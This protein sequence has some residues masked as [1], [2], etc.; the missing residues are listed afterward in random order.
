M[1][2]RVKAALTIMSIVFVI[3]AA[4]LVLSLSF[5]RQNMVKTIEQD[6]S[7]AI[8]IANDLVA[9]KISLLE[10][11]AAMVAERLLKADSV[12]EMT[13]LMKSQLEEFDDFISLTL[14]N[15]NEIIA[16]YGEPV[17]N[18][19]F[20]NETQYLLVVYHGEAIFSTTQYNNISGK[21]VMHLYVPMRGD[22]VL[23]AT[24]PG[25]L[26]TNLLSD[27]RL[28]RTG[29]I[30]MLDETGLIIAH[31]RHE[32]VLNRNNFILE[33]NTNPELQ[34]I[35]S[36]FQKII[37]S[38]QSLGTYKFEGVERL[39]IYKD[40]TGSSVRWHIAVSVPL[41]ESPLVTVR[42][43]LLFSALC[44][45]VIGVLISIFIS[46][47]VAGPFYKIEEQNRNLEELNEIATAA[48]EAKTIFLA[49][50]SHEM[51]T[52]L[53]AIIGF[54]ELSLDSR[55]LNEENETNI[56]K[57]YNSGITLLSTVN[58]ILDISKIEAGK[59]ELVPA[60]YETSSMLNDTITQ[61]VMRIGQ[62]PIKFILSISENMPACL[63]GDDLRIKQIISN[64]LSNAF[65][66]TKEGSVELG[67]SCEREG[68]T[69]WVTV[70][71]SDT[72]EGIRPEDIDKLFTNYSQMDTS[73][74]HHIEGTG[75]GLPI[76]KKTAEMMG[77]TITVESEYGKGSVFTVKFRQQFVADGVIGVEVV[78]SLKKFRY[79]DHKRRRGQNLVRINLSYARVLV[80]DDVTVNLDV[81]KGMMKPYRLLIDCATNGQ[82]AIDAIRAEKVRYNAI[83]MDHM[84]PGIDGVE[85]TRII[86]E[87][88]GT[89]YAKTVPIIALTA[90]AIAG[91]EEIFLS[92]GFQAFLTKPIEPARLDAVIHEW[93]RNTELEKTF[94]DQQINIGGQ[95][96]LDKRSG[97][98]RRTAE[99]RRGFDRRIFGRGISGL[100]IGRGLKFFNGDNESYLQVLHSYTV[101]IP[102]LID[103]AGKVNKENLADYATTVHGIKSSS[104]GIGAEELGSKAETL[105]KAAKE[106]DLDFVIANNTVFIAE[107]EKMISELNDL[108]RQRAAENQN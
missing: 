51:R 80:V 67:V 104:R 102:P 64:L 31:Y 62:K 70:R 81:A 65:K 38:E 101:N 15:R 40:I 88:I 7:I 48:S 24:I 41:S 8:E 74:N 27:Y 83:F 100:D 3:T 72:G 98:E 54:S 68:D 2:I 42:N 45:L 39:C 13:E 84:M 17:S 99:R 25:M 19:I 34:S 94:V 29:N 22:L 97:K 103:V 9:T 96:F 79:A 91:N 75:L 30:F 92:K 11:D 1:S 58:D 46:G 106:G 49:K 87:E 4:Y 5:T 78:N 63:Y 66:Y 86:R 26:F 47:L 14:H 59:F 53:T 6:L 105:E 56:E 60:E 57:V 32:F 69:V 50:M 33:S 43:D 55:Q 108:F 77:G 23:S 20:P 16:H 71:V 21:L 107:A 76:I 52:P 36:F 90:N 10:L 28:W 61:S 73:I 18:D 44:F 93:V 82:E 95:T 85:A 35:G 37:T 12:E 89:E